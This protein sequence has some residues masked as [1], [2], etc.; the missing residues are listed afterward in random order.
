[1]F[2]LHSKF[3][4]SICISHL[5]FIPYYILVYFFLRSVRFAFNGPFHSITKL[6]LFSHGILTPEAMNVFTSLRLQFFKLHLSDRHKHRRGRRLY[7]ILLRLFGLFCIFIFLWLDKSDSFVGSSSTAA[8]R[9]SVWTI[10]WCY[11]NWPDESLTHSNKLSSSVQNHAH[12]ANINQYYV[13]F[14]HW[15]WTNETKKKHTHKIQS[16]FYHDRA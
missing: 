13:K 1:M 2:I 16:Y 7:A 9:N 3:F 6:S 5:L 8:N 4:C 11:W 15:K 10:Y 12:C 14:A